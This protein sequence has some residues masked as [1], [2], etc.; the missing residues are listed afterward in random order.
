MEAIPCSA[1]VPN[2]SG[3]RG[4]EGWWG[5]PR[6]WMEPDPLALPFFEIRT[7]QGEGGQVPK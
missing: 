7:V 3:W 4:T 6:T 5:T 1:S 2:P